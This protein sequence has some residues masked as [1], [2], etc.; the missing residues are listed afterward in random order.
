MANHEDRCTHIDQLPKP[1]SPEEL[2]ALRKKGWNSRKR[3]HKHPP[4]RVFEGGHPL[5][6]S[7]TI[8]PVATD[9]SISFQLGP[10]GPRV[11]RL[12]SELCDSAEAEGDRMAFGW[13]IADLYEL[14]GLHCREDVPH[15]IEALR[16]TAPLFKAA[17]EWRRWAIG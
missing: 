4:I 14:D 5:L 10:T 11:T 9:Y 1:P 6:G 2:P 7:F 3:K 17:G 8:S 16:Q 15:P 13:L 12:M